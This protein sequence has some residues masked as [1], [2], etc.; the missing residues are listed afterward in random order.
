MRD[1]HHLNRW[2]A[3]AVL[4][5]LVVLVGILLPK[6]GG[7]LPA[8]SPLDARPRAVD[9]FKLIRKAEALAQPGIW[10]T[11]A[12]GTNSAAANPFFTA[13]FQPRPQPAPVIPAKPA[14]PATRKVELVYQGL[15]E[16]ADGRR[17]AFVKNGD[18]LMVV[19]IGARVVADFMIASID[20]RTLTLTNAAGKTN[21]IQFNQKATVE[22]PAQ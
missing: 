15:Y 13:Y 7:D 19:P 3:I 9:E 1:T 22:V 4:M 14:A 12:G 11:V 21:L 8:L 10:T 6:I 5:V 20:V 16:T 18:A 17:Q 2:L